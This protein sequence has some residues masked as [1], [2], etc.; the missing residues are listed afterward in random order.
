M[1][2][3]DPFRVRP[4]WTAMLAATLLGFASHTPAGLGV[5]DATIL[6]G[7]AATTRSR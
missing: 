3:D 2:H 4:N 5:F 7:L 1:S 6:I